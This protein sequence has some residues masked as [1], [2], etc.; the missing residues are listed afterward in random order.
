MGFRVSHSAISA[1]L[2]CPMKFKLKYIDKVKTPK[3]VSLLFGSA[4]HNAIEQGYKK[5]VDPKTIW[6]EIWEQTL[7]ENPHITGSKK[8]Y[9]KVAAKI[10]KTFQKLYPIEYKG[11]PAVEIWWETPLSFPEQGIDRP[12][13]SICGKID[14]IHKKTGANSWYP[15][16]I[17]DYKT[18]QNKP[19]TKTP[20]KSVLYNFDHDTQFTMYA[21]AVS[22]I[23]KIPGVKSRLASAE[24]RKSGEEGIICEHIHLRDYQEFRTTRIE[25]DFQEIF[26]LLKYFFQVYDSGFFPRSFNN[27]SYFCDF[28]GKVCNKA[29]PY[30]NW[31]ENWNQED[32]LPFLEIVRPKPTPTVGEAIVAAALKNPDNTLEDVEKIKKLEKLSHKP[33]AEQEEGMKEIYPEMK[34][35][36]EEGV[37]T[38]TE[39]YL[40]KPAETLEDVAKTDALELMEYN[41]KCPPDIPL[42]GVEIRKIQEEVISKIKAGDIKK[43]AANEEFQIR[44]NDLL[45]AQ[46]DVQDQKKVPKDQKVV[47]KAL[48]ARKKFEES[49][50]EAC[51]EEELRLIGERYI[52]GPYAPGAEDREEKKA[53]VVEIKPVQEDDDDD[54]FDFLE[55]AA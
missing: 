39:P 38:R 25:K 48:D 2:Q 40:K 27:C 37:K 11:K 31:N 12:D 8:S 43:D 20:S 51:T 6:G 55:E 46:K 54:F 30:A 23:L 33:L 42:S 21:W 18:N 32:E 19:L 5:E 17:A 50:A 47:F 49:G 1:L 15:I 36:K 7:D 22:E 53:D 45:E 4:V 10:W 34:A 3:S 14:L 16:I 29:C 24:T 52:I 28:A 26:D 44:I 13:D 41:F 35:V 9:D